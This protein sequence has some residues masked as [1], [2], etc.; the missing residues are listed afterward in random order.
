MNAEKVEKLLRLG[1]RPDAGFHDKFDRV[2]LLMEAAARRYRSIV[3]LLLI[4]GADPNKVT[5][6]NRRTAMHYAAAAGDVEIM[7]QLVKASGDIQ[8]LDIHKMSVLHWAVVGDHVAALKYGINKGVDLFTRDAD[9][10]SAL[11][12]AKRIRSARCMRYL[13]W[14]VDNSAKVRFMFVNGSSPSVR[15]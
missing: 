8:R 10:F 1:L 3:R 7:E 9:G 13:K 14:V 6:M 4:Y 15:G 2:T 5:K 11:Q 12:M